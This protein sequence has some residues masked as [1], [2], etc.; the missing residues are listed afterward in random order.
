M[1][2]LLIGSLTAFFLLTST[3]S[4]EE[5]ITVRKFLLQ[6]NE[7]PMRTF[8][9]GALG[10]A[11]TMC[12]DRGMEMKPIF[13]RTNSLGTTVDL[14]AVFLEELVKDNPEYADYDV[15]PMVLAVATNGV[16]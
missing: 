8:V 16:C 11:Y 1:K 9:F 5:L 15:I 6:Q 4:S 12:Q 14:L 10:G 2:K 7:T 13:Q 3:A